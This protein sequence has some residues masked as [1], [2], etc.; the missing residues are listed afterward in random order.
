[1]VSFADLWRKPLF[2]FEFSAL[3]I[4]SPFDRAG[5]EGGSD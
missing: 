1:M 3:L 4:L 2:R 5:T